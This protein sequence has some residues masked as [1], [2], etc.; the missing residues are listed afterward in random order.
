MKIGNEAALAATASTLPMTKESDSDGTAPGDE[1][2]GRTIPGSGNSA[3]T[4][5][6]TAMGTRKRNTER[7]PKASTSTP[8]IIGASASPAPAAKFRNPRPTPRWDGTS[9]RVTSAG[10][11]P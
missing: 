5:T 4:P 10:A 8:A 1:R 3:T 9:P 11:V 2:A 6:I 7:Q